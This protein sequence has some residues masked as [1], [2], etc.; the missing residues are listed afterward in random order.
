MPLTLDPQ[1]A[2][3][4]MKLF[5]DPP[6]PAAVGDWKTRRER[7]NHL[8]TILASLQPTPSDVTIKTYETKAK[9]GHVIKLRSYTKNGAKGSGSGVYYIHGGGMILGTAELYD[10]TVSRYVSNSGVPFVSVEYRLAP[11]DP[12]PAP[13]EDC[14]AGLVWMAEHAGE[15]GID[16]KRIA[17]MGDSAGGGLAAGVALIARDRG[18]PQLARQILIYP[19]LDDRTTKPDANI[20]PFATWTY[21]DNIT[22]WGAL[23]GKAPPKDLEY[24]APAHAKSLANLPPAYIEV[25]DLDVFRAEDVDYAQRL[26]AD[27]VATE[28]HVHPGAP[29][30]FEAFAPESDVAKRSTADRLR[31]IRGF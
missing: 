14:Y 30:G 16:A 10:A 21:D 24:A 22:G 1:V 31:Y 6:P 17:V 12:H 25:G 19:M 11:E 8:F 4:M 23:L 3:A 15:L 2:A 9:D 18:G 7:V 28:L 20:L 29:H 27:G 13:V 26:A 5:S